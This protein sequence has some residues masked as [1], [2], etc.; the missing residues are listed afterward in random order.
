MELVIDRDSHEPVYRQISRQIRGMVAAGALPAGFRLPPER[1]LARALGV[2]RSTVLQAY[3]ELKGEGL[4]DAHVGRG[5]SVRPPRQA[6]AAPA[7]DVPPLPWRQLFRRV[8]PDAL[9]PLVRD[10]LAMSERQDGISLAV[11]L[12][13]PELLPVQELRDVLRRLFD[14]VGPALLQHC[15]TEG[16]TPLRE[17]IAGLLARR[18]ILCDASEV[19]VLSGSQQ[20]LDLAAR[21]LLDPGD[22][23]VVEEPSF[24]GALQCF[25]AAQARLVG[26]PV[27][28]EGM[29]TDVLEWVLQRHRPKLIYTLPTFQ[30]PSGAVLSLERRRHLLEL[31]YRYQVPV[32]EDDPYSDLRYAGEPVPTLRTLDTHGYVLYLSTFSKVL[33]PGLRLGFLVAPRPAQRQMMLAKQA[34]DLHTNTPG[35]WLVDRFLRDG[36]YAP[37]LLR[38]REAYAARLDAMEATLRSCAPA[39]VTWQRPEG[40]FYVWCRLSGDVDARTLAT[41]AAAAGVSYLPGRS[42][43]VSEPAED[44]IRLNFSFSSPELIREGVRRLCTALGEAHAVPQ[45][46]GTA[47]TRPIV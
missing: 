43:L 45:A 41:H 32:L 13:A 26:V 22:V 24:F 40:G 5:T 44:H 11:G 34:V 47:E 36:L 20:G 37:H 35:Q 4:L 10:L 38:V 25:R 23:V 28:G 1:R 30:N 14:E 39:G 17:S 27:D 33:S 8:G 21:V 29:R 31:A 15:P 42:C 19:L 7:S 6:A 12:P 9:D 16:H 3:D 18:G 2:N 46:A